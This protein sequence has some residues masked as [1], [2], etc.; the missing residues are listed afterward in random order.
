[1]KI[2]KQLFFRGDRVQIK[3]DAGAWETGTV[4]IT[5]PYNEGFGYTID[6]DK[7]ERTGII[8]EDLVKRLKKG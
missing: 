2:R 3:N 8:P 4:A 6:L 5:Y 7:G 1:M